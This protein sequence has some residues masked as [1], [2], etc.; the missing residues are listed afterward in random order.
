[1]SKKSTNTVFVDGA[2]HQ[3]NVGGELNTVNTGQI[4]GSAIG[5]VD[6]YL[7]VFVDM[8]SLSLS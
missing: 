7:T 5:S 1:M 8:N 4:K 6:A 3:H 2:H